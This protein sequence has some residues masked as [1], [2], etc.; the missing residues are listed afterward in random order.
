MVENPHEDFQEFQK[1]P[2]TGKSKGGYTF[3]FWLPANYD[4]EFMAVGAFGQYLW[5][6]RKQKF[7]VAQ[8]STGQP[9]TS[10]G[11]SGATGEEMAAVMRTLGQAAIAATE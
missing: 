5:V 2:I 4:Q 6:D 7:V 10:R 3:Q 11:K 1:D 8:F 9:I